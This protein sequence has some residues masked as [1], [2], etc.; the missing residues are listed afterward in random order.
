VAKDLPQALTWYARA[1]SQGYA[2]AQFRL[3]AMHERGLGTAADPERARVWYARAAEQGHIKAMH[4]LAV[5]GISGGRTDYAAA[6]KWFGQAAEHGLADSQF[7]LAVLHQ[8]GLGVPRDLG[9]AYRWLALA[10]RSGDAEAANRASQVKA[11][12]SAPEVAAA[13][14]AIAAWRAR[15]PDP[16]VNEGAAGS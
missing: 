3:A 11:Q 16:A 7:N 13:E 9:Q 4:N 15:Q 12:L 14:G 5:L 2:P 8:G 1:A 10:A 6:A